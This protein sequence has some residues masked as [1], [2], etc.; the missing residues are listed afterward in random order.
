M[1][2]K[3]SSPENLIREELVSEN[4]ELKKLTPMFRQFFEIKERHPD[5][6]LLF[7]CGD[8]YEMYGQDAVV[9]ARAMEITLTSREVGGG[10]RIE[11]AG[12]PYHALDNYLRMLVTKGIKV[13]ICEQ[14][15]DPKQAKGLVKRDVTK[16]VTSG[17][18]LDLNMLSADK[19]NYLV[20]IAGF[21]ENTG[22][23]AADV[24][25][26]EMKVTSIQ[27]VELGKLKDEIYKIQPGEVIIHENTGGL[28]LITKYLS[29]LEIPFTVDSD[30]VHGE[31]FIEILK[32]VFR[33]EEIRGVDWRKVP[34]SGMAAGM[35]VQYLN[36]T[37][38]T[39][40][41]SLHNVRFYDIAD[42]MIL[43]AVT[44]RNLEISQTIIDRR[45]KGSLLWILDYT[46]TGMGARM[47][48]SWLEKP[49]LDKAEINTRL[50]AVEE[51][52]NNYTLLTAIGE[53]L[54]KI[55]DLERLTSRI[56][57]GGATARDLL[58]LKNSIRHLPELKKKLEGVR[59][60]LLK[61][62]SEAL[63]TL[64]D[65]YLLI[66]RSI[67]ED[68]PSSLKE[69]GT[70]KTGYSLEVDELRESRDAA[71]QWI[72][73]LENRERERTGIKSLK[74]G[75]SNVFGYYIDVTKANLHLVPADYT[76]KQTVAGGERFYCPELKE[77][78]AII[79]SAE[80]KLIKIELKIFQEVRDQITINS[81][82][83]QDT[84][85]VIASLD[86]LQSLA[87]AAIKGNFVRPEI[88][89]ERIIEIKDGRHP[90]VERVIGNDFVPNDTRIGDRNSFF[91]VITGPNMSGKST[92]LRQ[93]GI[94]TIMAQIG[95]FV[96]AKSARIGIADRVFTRVGASDDL[97]Q[98][99]STFLMEMQETANIIKNATSRSLILLDEI[100]RGTSTYDGMSIA[101]AVSEYIHNKIGA[102]TFFATHFHQLTEMADVLEG[103]KN[104]RVEVK[105]TGR[106]ITFL[107][108]I[109]PG[110]TDKSY[111]IY[112]AKLAGL[113]PV[114]L[115]RAGE[116]LKNLEQT[117]G[118]VN[119]KEE[120]DTAKPYQ[121]TFFDF[122]SDP[123]RDEI[124]SIN[125]DNLS[126]RDALELIYQWKN[127]ID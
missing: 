76:R 40:R 50:D 67:S 64:E 15:E 4:L 92:Y 95:S 78:E 8:F 91:H 30:P 57:Y 32:N 24:S 23:A 27:S 73:N 85:R 42:S 48:R 18:L 49:L 14:L 82:R 80:E 54:G 6:L 34:E 31:I 109:V 75:H 84:S 125:P 26:G 93:V 1:T 112:V 38:K 51:L 37:Q 100:G 61:V 105:E 113:P 47:L 99:Q 62:L 83:I 69:S 63:D 46:R 106:D 74:V 124:K 72:G 59:C 118:K 126:P 77:H 45:K 58:G 29:E 86:A 65:V 35:L 120:Q 10:R 117:H 56:I 22:I 97:H 19:N 107:H 25:T 13:A 127:K 79:Y 121:L 70:I 12:V 53:I 7:R 88:L 66:E 89:N 5:C 90:V 102:R 68:P 111:G 52:F 108:R 17:T 16:V 44:W 2:V 36:R 81:R 9:G 20:A 101:W 119:G 115:E 116:I 41:H 114:L 33:D 110:G 3:E 39:E 28:E 60:S 87:M 122:L 98:G 123:L 55:Y 43:D 96:P 11:M 103:V 71:K 94:I 21:G 104:F